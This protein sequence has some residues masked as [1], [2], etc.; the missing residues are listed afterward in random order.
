MAPAPWRSLTFLAALTL[1]GPSTG[2]GADDGAPA[3]DAAIADAP[4]LDGSCGV[5]DTCP[6]L[7]AAC[8]QGQA[9]RYGDWEHECT[10]SCT[11]S[12]LWACQPETIGSTC[13]AG[14]DA[15]P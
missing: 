10:C 6:D 2:C 11:A 9:C 12:G 13:Y 5:F 15:A 7:S 1:A 14:V 8:G 3:F 4:C